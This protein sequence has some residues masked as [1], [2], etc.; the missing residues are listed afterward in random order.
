MNYLTLDLHGL[1]HDEVNR[2]VFN[3]V[4]NNSHSTPLRIVTGNSPKMRTITIDAIEELGYSW[5]YEHWVETG[6]IIVT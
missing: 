3:F 4:F 2:T 1:F 5:H 6:A